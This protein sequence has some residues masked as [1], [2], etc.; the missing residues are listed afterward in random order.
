MHQFH[1]IW[2][3]LGAYSNFYVEPFNSSQ[4]M[5]TFF[6]EHLHGPTIDI[7]QENI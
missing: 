7:N 2:F 1:S 4:F 3:D 6:N 5:N